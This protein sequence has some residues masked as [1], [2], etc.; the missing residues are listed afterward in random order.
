MVG[1]HGGEAAAADPGDTR[2]LGFDAAARLGVVCGR[3]EL[4]LAGADL[5]G[6]GALPGLGKQLLG[7]KPVADLCSEP[8]TVEACRRKGRWRRAR[9]RPS[10]AGACRRSRARARRRASARGR[11]ARR[12]AARKRCRCAFPAARRPRR[13]ERPVRPLEAGT[14]PRPARSCSSTSCPWRSGRRRRSFRRGGPPRSP[15]R[16]RPARRSPR[17]ASTGPGRPQ[18][19]SGRSRHP[20]RG[21]RPAARPPRARPE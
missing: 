19:S 20:R 13:R 4:L 11:A 5:E 18:S 3:D 7:R 6:D 21:T 9:A 10:C 8:E 15:S 12:G 17:T 2:A 14:R 1:R 16:R